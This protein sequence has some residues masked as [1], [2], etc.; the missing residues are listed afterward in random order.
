MSSYVSTV[1]IND[2]EWAEIQRCVADTNTYVARQKDKARR[3]REE[4]DRRER[5]L[6]KLQTEL[7]VQATNA[8]TSLKTTFNKSLEELARTSHDVSKKQADTF[9]V[10][11]SE[12]RDEIS[13]TRRKTVAASQK[14]GHLSD[15]Y[16]KLISE[17]V[18]R[19]DGAVGKV[20]TYLESIHQIVEQISSM[21]PA[22]FEPDKYN[23]IVQLITSAETNLK[24]G[25]YEAALITA[26]NGSAKANHLLV[27]LIADNDIYDKE[28]VD[29]TEQAN[30]LKTRFD[31]LAPEM[32]GAISF[33][34]D[35]E[36]VEYEYDINHW[37]EGRFEQLRTT[38]TNCFNQ[39]QQMC[40]NKTPIKQLEALRAELANI[41]TQLTKCD[42]GA[43]Q[44]LL[45]SLKAQEISARLCDSLM[46]NDWSLEEH[47]FEQADDRNPYTMTYKDGAGNSISI[48]VSPGDTAEKPNIFLEAFTEEESHSDIIKRNVQATLADEGISIEQT[49]RLSD[50]QSHAN[51]DAFI[52]HTLSGAKETNKQRRQKSFR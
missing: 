38:F 25:S 23:E 44:E 46:D 15:E 19:S 45:G 36:T 31:L 22:V 39:L 52:R 43:R 9:D 7:K 50:C 42:I 34:L 5:D 12:L 41:D 10:G 8:A 32:H 47:G 14:I 6:I 27:E 49:K 24:N 35:G 33:D 20:Q 40:K 2:A 26:Q 28:L 37:S 51:G 3:I 48:I 13:A 17:L 11:I 30:E 16:T 21:N 1:T 4:A 29:A 18:S